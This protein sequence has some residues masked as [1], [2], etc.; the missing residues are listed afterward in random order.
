[1]AVVAIDKIREN[2]LM[3]P[4]LILLIQFLLIERRSL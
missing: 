4:V 3:G 1:M 2:Y